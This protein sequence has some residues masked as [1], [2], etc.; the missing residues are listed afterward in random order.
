MR[1][2]IAFILLSFVANGQQGILGVSVTPPPPANFSEFEA[3]ASTLTNRRYSGNPIITYEAATWKARQVHFPFIIENPIHTDSL[4]MFYGGG[5][6]LEGS[7]YRIGRAMASK[8]NPF[9]WVEYASNPVFEPSDFVGIGTIVGVDDARWN[10]VESRFELFCC[11]YNSGQS[12]SWL[13]K[14]Y[15]DDGFTF[16]YEGAL[17]EPD[18]DET[19]LGNSGILRDGATWYC[20]YTYRTASATLPGIRIA[21]STDEGAT[22]T[23]HGDFLTL[24]SSGAYDD[25]YMEGVQFL[26]IGSDYVLNYGCA[27]NGATIVFSGALASS[28]TALGTYTKSSI[29]PYFTHSGSGWDETQVSTI[30]VFD[31]LVFYQGSAS[32]GDYNLALWS[33][34][35]AQLY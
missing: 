25:K 13:G 14:Y 28:T 15:S 8:A 6:V 2:I 22:W 24:G 4:I 3:M 17:I 33:M 1:L 29:N 9:V 26:K 32:A 30:V 5:S 10:P 23:K 20:A 35:I 31:R 27:K 19:F 21:S 12:S 16:T 11:T 18:G 7:L 34:G